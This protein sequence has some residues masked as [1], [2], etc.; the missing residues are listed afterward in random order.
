MISY[1][2]EQWVTVAEMGED[3]HASIR[4][5][6]YHQCPAHHVDPQHPTADNISPVGIVSS[7]GRPQYSGLIEKFNKELRMTTGNPTKYCKQNSI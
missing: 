3:Q 7:N 1:T 5:Q 6:D 4:C 2:G